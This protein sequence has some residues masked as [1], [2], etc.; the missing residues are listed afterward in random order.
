MQTR[1]KRVNCLLSCMERT[2][3]RGRHAYA[4]NEQVCETDRSLREE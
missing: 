2:G 1:E 4:A 3:R